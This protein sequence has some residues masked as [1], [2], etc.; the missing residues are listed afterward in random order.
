MGFD[1]SAIFEGFDFMA[2]IIGLVQLVM[3]FIGGF[4]A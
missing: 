2:V 1:F 3:D 4:I